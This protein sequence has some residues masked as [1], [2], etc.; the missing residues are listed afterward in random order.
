MFIINIIKER[1]QNKKL[2]QNTLQKKT[3]KIHKEIKHFFYKLKR[4]R[5]FIFAT[6]YSK[7]WVFGVLPLKFLERKKKKQ[8]Q[9]VNLAFTNI[10]VVLLLGISSF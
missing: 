1:K 8:Q 9:N 6:P 4:R 3:N 7:F 5:G 10:V 2:K